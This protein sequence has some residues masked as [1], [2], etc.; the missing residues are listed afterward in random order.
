MGFNVNNLSEVADVIDSLHKTPRYVES[1]YSMVR[2][3]DV[4]YGHLKL[5]QTF[6][7]T[8]EV[9]DDFS[10]RYKPKKN[11][12]IITRVGSYGITAIVGESAFCLGQN[13]S[14]IIPKINPR[15]LYAVLNS[16]YIRHQ[17]E[18]SVVGSTQKTLSLKAIKNLKIPRFETVVEDKIAEILGGLDD[19]IELNSQTNQTL[20]QI[21]QAIFKSWFVDFEPVKAKQHIR[22]LGGNGEQTERAAQAVIAGAV[23]LENI[24]TATD[25]SELDWQVTD[26]LSGKLAH[27]TE[28]QREQLASTARQFPDRLVELESGLIPEGWEVASID[29]IADVIDCLHS[30]KPKEVIDG[31]DNLYLQLNN[32]GDDGLLYL[33][34][35]F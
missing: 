6:K 18:F 10:K 2:C 32:I 30:K 24:T 14:A 12:I 1:G 7:V 15:Y 16:S 8:E 33:D 11:D 5:D 26:A 25:L 17:I 22:A 20:E 3:T 27:Q 19:K 28:A 21:A 13:T 31:A 9:F 35:A 4:K 23:N 29:D 34:K